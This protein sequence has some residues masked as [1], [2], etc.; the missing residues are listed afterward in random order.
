MHRSP[1]PPP[2]LQSP[3]SF[4][5]FGALTRH[6]HRLTRA[7]AEALEAGA[8][9]RHSLAAINAYNPGA[10]CWMAVGGMSRLCQTAGV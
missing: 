4:G 9:D 8:V 10:G 5:G 6:L 7:I 3:L 1:L 2:P